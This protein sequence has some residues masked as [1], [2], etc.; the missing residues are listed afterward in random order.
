VGLLVD[1][2]EYVKQRVPSY[3]WLSTY[4]AAYEIAAT[5]I[6][7][8]ID[9]PQLVVEDIVG[10]DGALIAARDESAVRRPQKERA[11]G[12]GRKATKRTGNRG[13][14]NGAKRAKNMGLTRETTIPPTRDMDMRM[15]RKTKSVVLDYADFAGKTKRRA[16]PS[17]KM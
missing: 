3:A 1:M 14:S 2:A 16:E 9:C 11:P 17:A 8:L 5:V 12:R 10:K 13:S 6:P 4:C 7:A 15:S